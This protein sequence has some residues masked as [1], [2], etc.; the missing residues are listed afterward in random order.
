ML[1]NVENRSI[2]GGPPG[3]LWPRLVVFLVLSFGAGACL[4]P[5]RTED[6]KHSA[7]RRASVIALL[8]FGAIMLTSRT[9]VYQHHLV[10]A[11]PLAFV[12]AALGFSRLWTR[13]RRLR[14][15][16]AGA[17]VV[18]LG[19]FLASDIQNVRGL[20]ATRGYGFWSI[21]INDVAQELLARSPGRFVQ[22]LDWGFANN[23][24]VL[25]RGEV[26][27]REIFFGAD[28][29]QA[30]NGERWDSV[31]AKG[32][33]F[34]AGAGANVQFPD[35]AA[36]FR[37]AL[38]RS[39]ARRH[40]TLFRQADGNPYAELFDVELQGPPSG[41][42]IV[43]FVTPASTRVGEGFQLQPDG[44]SAVGEAFGP[45]CVVVLAGQALPTVVGGPGWVTAVVPRERFSR[46]GRLEVRVVDPERGSSAAVFFEVHP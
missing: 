15:V 29:R 27:A 9:P 1:L 38:V 39:G 19:L 3:P 44:S 32:G 36:G 28:R 8:T 11:L 13:A 7:L 42:P 16:L 18:T 35:P 22:V 21:A 25:S 41:V 12:S 30:A 31:V 33:L 26:T 17:A 24:F 6:G 46:P 23:L 5:W 2:W 20:R 14:G 40:S 37:D 34:L 10:T 45:D 43:H 4:L